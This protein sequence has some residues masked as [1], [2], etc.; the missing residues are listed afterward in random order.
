MTAP[1]PPF[2]PTFCTLGDTLCRVRFFTEAEWAALA[3]G[4]RP[5]GAVHRPGSGYVAAVLV[6]D[7]S[8]RD[9]GPWKRD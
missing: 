9:S 5:A 2:D 4:R 6:A 7:L 8:G 3:P 1:T